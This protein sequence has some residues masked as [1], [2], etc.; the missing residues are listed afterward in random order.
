MNRAFISKIFAA[1]EA[2]LMQSETEGL[3]LNAEDACVQTGRPRSFELFEE[4]S[5]KGI[6]ETITERR[7]IFEKAEARTERVAEVDIEVE[8]FRVW[9][10]ETKSLESET[11]HYYSASLKSL[12]LGLPIGE[13]VAYLFGAILESLTKQNME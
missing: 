1:D 10:G 2:L 8:R 9:L 11:A 12:L 13:Q 6:T 3:V 7:M 4:F 5:G